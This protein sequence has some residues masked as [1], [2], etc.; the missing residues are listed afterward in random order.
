MCDTPLNRDGHIPNLRP[1]LREILV[2]AG[3]TKF[4]ERSYFDR[5]PS[6]GVLC[7]WSHVSSKGGLCQGGPPWTETPAYG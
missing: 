2:I 5:C 4:G 7:L 3:E 6:K 1:E